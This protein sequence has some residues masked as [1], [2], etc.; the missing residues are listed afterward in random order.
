MTLQI[1]HYIMGG[2]NTTTGAFNPFVFRAPTGGL[3][4]LTFVA[5]S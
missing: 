4:R 3:G 2:Q 5:Q 1:M